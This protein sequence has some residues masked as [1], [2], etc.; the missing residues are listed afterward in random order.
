MVKLLDKAVRTDF[1]S[2]A[3]LLDADI[4]EKH[5]KAIKQAKARIRR[6][7]LADYVKGVYLYSSTAKGKARPNSDIDLLMI[8]DEDI[9]NRPRCN[10][11][12][13]YLKGGTSHRM[14]ATCRRRTCIWN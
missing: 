13:T 10:D 4:D 9:K 3:K 11:W 12:I 7:Q 2:T 1:P 6:S 14:T 5:L 8:L